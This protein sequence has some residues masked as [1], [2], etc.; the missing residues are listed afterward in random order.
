MVTRATWLASSLIV[1]TFVPAA[2]AGA[3]AG[4]ATQQWVVNG[5]QGP[6]LQSRSVEGVAPSNGG[7]GGSQAMTSNGAMWCFQSGIEGW[8]PQT[9]SIGNHGT[10]AF[11]EVGPFNSYTRIFS[12]FD[13]SPPVPVYQSL[14][15]VATFNQLVDSADD[16]DTHVEMYDVYSDSTLMTHTVY[17]KKCSASMPANNWS[18]TF[19]TQTNGHNNLGVKISRN[20]QTIVAAVYNIW[21]NKTDVVVFNSSSGTP[22]SSFSVSTSGPIVG[23]VL[24]ADG[25]RL[26]LPTGAAISIVA[27]PSGTVVATQYVFDTTYQGYALSGDGS[28]YAYGTDNAVKVYKRSPSTGVYSLALTHTVTGTYCNEVTISADGS[29]LAAAFNHTDH[30]L[31]VTIDAVD[32][33]SGNTTMSHTATGTGAYENVASAISISGDGQRFAVGLWGDQV[34]SVPQIEIFDRSQSNPI[35]VYTVPGS[36]TALDLSGDGNHVAVASKSVHANASGTGGRIEMYQAGNPDFM[37]H[38]VPHAGASVSFEVHG[39][40]GSAARLLYSSA[41]AAPPVFYPGIGTLFLD[42]VNIHSMPMGALDGTGVGQCGF[43]VPSTVATTWYFQGFTT[44]PRKLTQAWV[45]VTV[46]P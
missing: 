5:P 41:A 16:N 7:G 43:T 26:M 35:N 28:T 44:A 3:A 8:T 10:E 18:F 11:S 25:T 21:T 6:T 42:R 24:S 1:F 2:R 30:F 39:H 12:E 45:P 38:G 40:P 27:I 33:A 36:V 32:L 20:G 4:T 13:N 19:P 37:L 15:T 14:V 17:V 46:L 9:V 31:S 29:T 34:L 22:I 23:M